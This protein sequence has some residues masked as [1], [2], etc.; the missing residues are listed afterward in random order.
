MLLSIC[1][2]NFNR[3]KSLDNCLN[4]IKIAK[5]R[6]K[7][8]FEVCISDNHSEENI[9]YVVRKYKKY[10]KIKF[11]KNKRN[12]GMGKNIIS[13]VAMAKGEFVWIIGNDDLLLPN[14]LKRLSKI[15]LKNKKIDFFFVN[16]YLLS[17]NFI[18]NFKQPFNT[19][20]LPKKMKK[21]SNG[22]KNKVLNFHDLIDP[23][24]SFDYL[25]G[26]YFS[27]FRRE[28]W[29]KNLK[30]LNKTDLSK[31]EQFSTFDNTC[32]HIK[33][34]SKAFANSKAFFC[35]DALSVNLSGHREWS[36]LYPFIESV[37]IPET[38]DY[39][40]KY[41]YPLRKY[42][43]C[44]NDSLK[45]FLPSLIKI[46]LLGKKGGLYNINIKKNFIN[47]LIFPNFYFSFI[48]GIFRK[49]KNLLK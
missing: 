2:P 38:L 15:I 1:I 29:N 7:L 21:F 47:N 22:G 37:R 5:R 41:G 46:I 39:Y 17:T 11:R 35:S 28:K 32:P 42:Y 13:S 31:S 34:F 26:L 49:A 24:I 30:V 9:L 3:S 40:F 43:L 6:T 20:K 16:S 12:F 8:N 45:N 44:K 4:S 18:S 27:V 23:K 48:Y 10:L 25:L 14:S 33:I 36:N 19:K